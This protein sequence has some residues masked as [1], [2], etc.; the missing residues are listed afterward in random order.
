MKIVMLE[1][2]S[3]GEEISVDVLEALGELTV[4]DT[5]GYELIADRIKD[6]DVVIANKSPLN[7][8]TMSDAGNLKLI[9]ELAT[10][11]DNVDTDYCKTRGIR[12]C[13]VRGYST[14][15]VVQHTFGLLLYVFEK[16]SFYDNFVKSGEYSKQDSFCNYDRNFGELSGKTWGIVGMGAIGSRVAEIASSFG[17]RVVHYSV[18]NVKN[19][20]KYETL[21]FD[22]FLGSSDIISIHCP[23]NDDT[24]GLFNYDTFTRMKKDAILIN[25]ARGGIVVDADLYRALNENLIYGAGL[26]V[27]STEPMSNDNPL[28]H[29]MDSTRLIITPHMAWASNEARD[30]VVKET[31]LNIEAFISGVERNVIVR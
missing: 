14:E 25:V 11:Y 24:R 17:M 3:V 28:S 15:A 9:C 18:R 23:L 27:T 1:R 6:A 7:E 5:T 21:T 30:R 26:D 31:A 10:G 29:F 12:L 22:E 4:Y 8:S 2:S 13:N 19:D 16:L 20:C